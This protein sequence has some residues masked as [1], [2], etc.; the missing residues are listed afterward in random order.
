MKLTYVNLRGFK[1]FQL[2]K[3]HEF[4]AEFHSPVTVITASNGYGKTSLLTELNPMPS[5]RTNYEKNGRKELHFEHNGHLFKLISDFSNRVAPHKFLMD[6]VELNEGHTTEVQE[7]LVAQHFGVTIPIRNLIYG[8][9]ELCRMTKAE[10]K[11]L[12]LNINPMDLSLIIP[13]FKETTNKFKACKANLQLLYS[14]KS[15][16]ESKMIKQEVLDQHIKTKEELNNQILEID[17][18]LYGLEQHITSLQNRFKD[19]LDY[20]QD[21][22]NNNQTL[23]PTKEILQQCEDIIKRSTAFTYMPRGEEFSLRK[24][25]LQIRKEQLLTQKNDISK[26]IENISRE[27]NEYQQHLDSAQSRP[28]S[29]MEKEITEI[30]KKLEKYVDLPQNPLPKNSIENYRNLNER[31][32]QA[33]FIFRDSEVKLPK[34]DELQQKSFTRDELRRSLDNVQMSF[35]AR[36]SELEE[37][38][39]QITNREQ[40]ARIPTNCATVSCGLRMLFEEQLSKLK[41]REKDLSTEIEQLRKVLG[42]TNTK[43]TELN[44]FLKPIEQAHL[45]EHYR[46]LASWL[47]HDPY[48]CWRDWNT[49]LLDILNTQPMSIYKELGDLIAGSQLHYEKQ[50]LLDR[51]KYLT[52]TLTTLAK[53]SDASLEFLKGKLREK[54][55]LIKQKLADLKNIETEAKEVDSTYALYLEYM[56]ATDQI[57][58]FQSQYE[59]G[60]R[61]LVVAQAIHYWKQL[62]KKFLSA[63]SI[64]SEDLRKIET[65]VQDQQV[66]RRTYES[67]TLNLVD[68]IEQD[69]K[70]YGLIA[71]ALSPNSG[72]PHKSMVRYLNALINNVNYFISQVWTYKMRILPISLDQDLDYGFRIE[73]GNELANDINVLSEGQTEM[74][75]L[76]WMLTILLQMKL[77]NKIPLY[78]DELG[79]TFDGIHRLRLLSFLNQ[80]IDGKYIEQLF[81]VSHYSEFTTGF[82]DSEIICLSPDEMPDLPKNVNE[83]ARLVVG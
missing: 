15:E 48:L 13:A 16:L 65:I 34:L 22:I 28:I 43:L 52:D 51:K 62:G 10:R 50:E 64:L 71:E 73:V 20:R 70:I 69:K 26:D 23:L 66:L 32:Q 36:Q 6:E 24:N 31:F 11:N 18:I 81:L 14:R 8:K 2:S 49:E 75:N 57:K 67:E 47:C 68:K 37:I 17:K 83:H 59:K 40:K 30:D 39:K 76:V 38:K 25:E 29:D 4:E 3:I 74:V 56:S 78:A 21:C 1:R 72:F 33:L 9:T 55:V 27:I 42:E 82:T 45:Q 7:E 53:Q 79:R 35:S 12:F 19:D 77:L 60:E 41:N 46:E 58:H 5:V 61:A 63:K 54:E 44:D 80:L